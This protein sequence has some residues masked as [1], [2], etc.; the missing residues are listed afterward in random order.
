ME[1]KEQKCG[2]TVVFAA[3]HGFYSITFGLN[4]GWLIVQTNYVCF[5]D[6]ESKKTNKVLG[7]SANCIS[8]LQAHCH[9]ISFI[10]LADSSNPLCRIHITT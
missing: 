1:K 10:S 3:Q 4:P 2:T 9:Q 5:V 7:S 6:S 8:S